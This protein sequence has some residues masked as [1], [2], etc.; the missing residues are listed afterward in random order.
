MSILL[1]DDDVVVDNAVDWDD[2]FVFVVFV[3]KR[4][5][6]DDFVVDDDVVLRDNERLIGAEEE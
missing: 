3:D 2:V 4:V 1:K 6:V 5:V